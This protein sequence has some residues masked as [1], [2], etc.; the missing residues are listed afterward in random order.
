MTFIISLI[1]MWVS[2]FAQTSQESFFLKQRGVMLSQLEYEKNLELVVVD[3]DTCT[4][5]FKREDRVRT[6]QRNIQELEQTGTLIKCRSKKVVGRRKIIADLRVQRVHVEN[7]QTFRAR[8]EGVKEDNSTTPTKPT[9]E[10]SEILDPV[11][12]SYLREPDPAANSGTK[13]SPFDIY[14]GY[15]GMPYMSKSLSDDTIFYFATNPNDPSLFSSRDLPPGLTIGDT[16]KGIII[17]IPRKAGLFSPI[18][19]IGSYLNS[20]VFKG[21]VKFK[22]YPKPKFT[23]LNPAQR[24]WESAIRFRDDYPPFLKVKFSSLYNDGKGTGVGADA[25]RT[26]HGTRTGKFYFEVKV[27]E[28]GQQGVVGIDIGNSSLGGPMSMG[29]KYGFTFSQDY[30]DFSSGANPIFKKIQKNDIM[31]VAYDAD[32]ANLWFGVNGKWLKRAATDIVDPAKGLK[33]FSPSDELAR[34][35]KIFPGAIVRAFV[36]GSGNTELITNFGDQPWTYSLPDGFSGLQITEFYKRFPNFWDSN[37]TS[38]TAVVDDAGGSSIPGTGVAS[39]D[40][41]VLGSGGDGILAMAPKSSGRWQ[42]EIK[43]YSYAERTSMG[44]APVNFQTDKLIRLGAAGTNSIGLRR[45]DEFASQTRKGV[46]EVNG[47][48]NFIENYQDETRFTFD[49][50]FDNKTVTIYADG[51]EIFKNPLPAYSGAW[52]IAAT[53]ASTNAWL[54]TQLP[55]QGV[56]EGSEMKYPVPG[57]K[58]WSLDDSSCPNCASRVAVVEEDKVLECAPTE[59][60]REGSVYDG[61]SDVPHCSLPKTQAQMSGQCTVPSKSFACT[62]DG[63]GFLCSYY[64]DTYDTAERC[65][66]ECR[67]PEFLL[68]KECSADGTW[69]ANSP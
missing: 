32:T 20:S 51:K 21:P 69:G 5:P 16:K 30:Q 33:P 28:P 19:K 67:I 22:I 2:V 6:L 9:N 40:L 17:G 29:G 58:T 38:A 3:P 42:F 59:F 47:K 14:P 52:A 12:N 41:F 23:I 56:V 39:M 11:D 27:L 7:I 53:M 45:L 55:G 44:I 68:R 13:P 49:C 36:Q 63:G 65:N 31:M 61:T 37:S 62:Q 66:A 35:T 34:V 54:Y 25:V 50:D 24:P 10:V 26:L 57:V 64:M 1:F 43:S 8:G 4:V 46:V 15:E 48:I 60:T 18:M